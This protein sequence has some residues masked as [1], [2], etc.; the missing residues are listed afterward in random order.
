MEVK[1]TKQTKYKTFLPTIKK[2]ER[3]CIRLTFAEAGLVPHA[4][5]SCP[6]FQRH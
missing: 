2:R 1:K 5:T 3:L 4:E 6:A